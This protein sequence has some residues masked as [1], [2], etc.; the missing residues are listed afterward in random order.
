MASAASIAIANTHMLIVILYGKSF[1]QLFIAHHAT[2]KATIDAIM[3]SKRKFF[4]NRPTMLITLA[5]NTFLIP[6][7]LERCSVLNADKPNKPIEPTIMAITAK[8]HK[9]LLSF[10]SLLY[11][12]P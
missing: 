6:I 11:I 8:I 2:G 9:R 4:D 3:I 12:L 7:S 1:S 10:S 5:P